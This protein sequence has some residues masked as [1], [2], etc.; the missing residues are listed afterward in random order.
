MRNNSHIVIDTEETR[1]Y[2]LFNDRTTVINDNVIVLN[3]TEE[4]FKGNNFLGV[5]EQK[6]RKNLQFRN[7]W[8][9]AMIL[10]NLLREVTAGYW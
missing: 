7:W 6:K 3:E 1:N 10:R 8:T 2:G 9:Q 5:A 4:K